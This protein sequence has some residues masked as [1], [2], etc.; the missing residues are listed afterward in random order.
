[1]TVDAHSIAIEQILHNIWQF[2]SVVITSATSS[3]SVSSIAH[4]LAQ[5]CTLAGQ[6]TLLV[7]LNIDCP[8]FEKM[9]ALNNTIED[10]EIFNAPAL[11]CT[12]DSVAPVIGITAPNDRAGITKLRKPG[13]LESYITRWQEHIDTII[14][15]AA[16]MN[17]KNNHII[18]A[19]QVAAV[20]DATFLVIEAGMTQQLSIKEACSRLKR[21]NA[22]LA[23]CILDETYNPSLKLELLRECQRVAPYSKRLA[24]RLSTWIANN[25]FLSIDD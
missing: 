20:S 14:I 21:A 6:R 1:M 5:R 2:R 11:I 19:E 18:S 10:D 4:A 15:D 22:N 13:V 16:E 7:D 3:N 23:G 12:Q 17:C 25:R 8:Q 9:I 24:Q